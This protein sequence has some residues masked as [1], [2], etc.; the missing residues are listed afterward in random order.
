MSWEVGILLS[1]SSVGH[2]AGDNVFVFVLMHRP[3]SKCTFYSLD[4]IMVSWHLYYC[5]FIICLN[6][7]CSRLWADRRMASQKR[8][9]VP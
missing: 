3:S 6:V 5:I 7:M 1:L 2:E 4:R 9:L 8:L